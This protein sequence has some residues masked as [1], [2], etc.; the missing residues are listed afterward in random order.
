MNDERRRVALLVDTSTDFGRRLIR[1][2]GRRA[3][4]RWDLWIEPRGQQA[5][6]GLRGWRG[7]G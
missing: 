7:D 2:I 6:A 4:V 3:P 1:G 5:P